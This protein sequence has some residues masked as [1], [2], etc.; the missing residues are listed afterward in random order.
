MRA[1]SLAGRIGAMVLF[2]MIGLGIL[3]SIFVP[4]PPNLPSGPPL[5]PPSWPHILGT[6]DLGVDLWAQL[7]RGARLSLLVGV[8]SALLAVTL[9]GGLGTAAGY[10]GGGADILFL[11]FTDL[12]IIL[13]DLPLLITAGAFLGSGTIPTILIIA[14]LS[15]AVPARIVRSQVLSLKKEGYVVAAV[16]F[17]ASFRHLV[18]KHFAP[19]I[20][21][22]LCVGA[23]R[24]MGRAVVAEASLSFLGLGDPTAKSWGLILHHAIHFNGIFFTEY[25]K[26]WIL[27]PTLALTLFVGSVALVARDLERLFNRKPYGKVVKDG[28]QDG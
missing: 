15:W 28:S 18:Q 17:G 7:C 25:W 24:I 4:F 21:P 22:I 8:S 20:V 27:G 23:L 13:P 26:W 19:R 2:S 9:G 6:D 16:A 1:L 11:R 14:L 5:S 10:I 3:G 12:L